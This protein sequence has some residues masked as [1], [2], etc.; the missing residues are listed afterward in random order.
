[1]LRILILPLVAMLLFSCNK[2]LTQESALTQLQ[3]LPE[4][5]TPFYAPF[6]I[7]REV[8]SGKDH[9]NPQ[10][11]IS[12][13]LGKLTEAGLLQAKISDK[14]SWR[15]VLD[16]ELTEAGIALTDPKRKTENGVYV[17]V[18]RVTPIEVTEM[19]VVEPDKKVEVDYLFAEGDV[20]PFGEHLEF[21]NGKKHK[22]T[23][24][25]IRKGLGWV[26]EP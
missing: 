21:G 24:T 17:Q 16:I 6:H 4:F 2:E 13:H 23:R 9:E 19:R 14:N 26:V 11:Y 7:G 10:A 5:Q 18:C 12:Q 1:M 3:E 22:D 25:F 15:T 8:L 20:T